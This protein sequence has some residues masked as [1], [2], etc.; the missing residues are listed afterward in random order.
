MIARPQNIILLV[1]GPVGELQYTEPI[2]DLLLDLPLDYGNLLDL[3]VKVHSSSVSV[4]AR[5]LEMVH[6]LELE[7]HVFDVVVLRV[8]L[9]CWETLHWR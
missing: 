5:L 6:V 3:R 1:I 7:R 9:C 2:V 8:F 4:A